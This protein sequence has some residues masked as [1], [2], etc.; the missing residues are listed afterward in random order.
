MKKGHAHD[1]VQQSAR[2]CEFDFERNLAAQQTARQHPIQKLVEEIEEERQQEPDDGVLHVDAQ[3]DRG[4][5][6]AA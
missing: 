4:G 1:G 2:E 5:P 3:T 6:A